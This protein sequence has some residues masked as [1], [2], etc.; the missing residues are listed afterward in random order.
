MHTILATITCLSGALQRKT[1]IYLTSQTP[2]AESHPPHLRLARTEKPERTVQLVLHRGQ[3]RIK[4]YVTLPTHSEL[5]RA[6]PRPVESGLVVCLSGL[7][8][9]EISRDK[10]RRG[11]SRGGLLERK[12][13][14]RSRARAA[15]FL[16]VGGGVLAPGSWVVGC[17][18]RRRRSESCAVPVPPP[19]SLSLST[20]QSD[21]RAIQTLFGR[22]RRYEQPAPR[23]GPGAPFV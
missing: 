20:Q 17:P 16:A 13:C 6:G 4:V 19:V 10:P 3:H 22:R 1:T 23:R 15:G 9:K 2:I 12:L 8:P 14:T 21:S 5:P 11:R 7:R 18:R